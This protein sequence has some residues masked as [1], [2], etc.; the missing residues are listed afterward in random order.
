MSD[1]LT[2][3]SGAGDLV[4]VSHLT[5]AG[6][7]I[8]VATVHRWC[9]RGVRGTRLRSILIGGKRFIERADLEVFQASINGAGG[10]E[11]AQ[12]V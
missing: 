7:P 9:S 6:R 2:M 10:A 1:R 11:F 3:D 5:V 4:P 12:A 8:P